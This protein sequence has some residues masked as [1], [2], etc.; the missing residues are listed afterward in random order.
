MFFGVG[1]QLLFY[2]SWFPCLD[3]ELL[4]QINLS[5]CVWVIAG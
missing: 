2:V 1:G 3:Q 4:N 5:D